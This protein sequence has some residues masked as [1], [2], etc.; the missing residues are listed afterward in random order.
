[1]KD[2]HLRSIRDKALAD[3]S[4]WE[5]FWTCKG[6]IIRNIYELKDSIDVMDEYTFRYHVNEDNQKNDFSKWI[7]EVLG[8]HELMLSLRDVYDKD[9][10]VR[11]IED[12]IKQLEAA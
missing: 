3:C 6:W 7:D 5:E 10:Y 4:P 11:V 1:M 12:R 2:A 9:W 8:D